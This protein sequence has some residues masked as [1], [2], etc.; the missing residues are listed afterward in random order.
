MS[1]L[2]RVNLRNGRRS[3]VILGTRAVGEGVIGG[4]YIRGRGM[5]H[6][7]KVIAELED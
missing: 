7:L 4:C 3:W 2:W 6:C 1:D 5:L